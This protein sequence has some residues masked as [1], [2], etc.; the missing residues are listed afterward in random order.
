MTT[1]NGHGFTISPPPKFRGD[2]TISE[3]RTAGGT[4]F[5]VKD[6]LSG[7][8]F[9]LGEA[10]RFIAGQF[11]GT[12]SL[13]TVRDRVEARF[14]AT[15]PTE[16]L[17]AFVRKVEKA[18][19]L[20]TAAGT[21]PRPSSVAQRRLR[22]NLL[23]L[24]FKLLDPDRIL[25]WLVGRVR[26]CFT[27]AFLVFAGAMI[28]FAAGTVTANWSEVGRNLGAVLRWSA[29][30]AYLAVAFLVISAH[31]FAHGL[32]CKHFGGEV[33]EMG[34]LLIYFQPALYCNVSDAW[35]FPEKSK[36]LWVGFAGPFFELFLWALA[37]LTW[38]L[39]ET[40]TWLNY[41]AF[42]VVT[43]SGIKTLFNFNPLIKLDGYYLLSDYLGIPNLRKKSFRHLGNRIKEWLGFSAASAQAAPARERKIF[44]LYGLVATAGSLSLLAYVAVQAGGFLIEQQQMLA[45]L[46]LSGLVSNRLWRRFRKLFGRPSRAAS[47]FDGDDELDEPDT[48]GPS[49][50][51]P[52]R[53]KRSRT[54]MRWLRWTALTGA[55]CA[56]LFLGRME[57]RIAGPFNIL[58]RENA[59]VRAGVEGIIETIHVDEGDVVKVG[60]LVARL[61]DLDLLAELRQ[62][63][64]EIK[65]TR[66][67]LMM[68]EAGPTPEEIAVARTL[69]AKAED[70]R[71]YALGRLA[72]DQ[73][74]FDQRL[75]SRKELEDTQ[76]LA[77]TAGNDLEEARTRLKILLRGT[78]PEE[79]AATKAG[80]DR[81]EAQRLHLEERLRLL[82][83]VSPAD[84]IVATPTRQLKELKRQL[85]N[86]GDLI[87][88]V[89]DFRTVTAEILIPEKEIAD[90]QVGQT[91][92]LKARAYP[93]QLFHGKVTAI[94]T[95]ALGH[96]SPAEAATPLTS[97][98][99]SRASDSNKSV[100]VTTQIENAAL[101]LKPEMTGQ[102]KIHCGEQRIFD[103]VTRRLARVVKVEFWS[104]W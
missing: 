97:S 27:P 87:A 98:S 47:P 79:I 15:V 49:T 95:A 81:L 99:A 94:A 65:Q 92:L 11:D 39:T 78:R 77:A 26:F 102:A 17:T 18:G 36:R 48:P 24:R 23:Y 59:D 91:V 57:L 52:P 1:N 93:D 42:I 45:L 86:R 104:W 37:V 76:E 4:V 61:S 50:P 46:L 6:P 70:R 84:G 63:E 29:I 31:E 66:A 88:K 40:G 58:P 10:E 14:G 22:G 85:V 75:L 55:A 33:R 64:A 5:V 56:V 101:L 60:D 96:S 67:R 44:L 28:L 62:T 54:L 83:V 53:R 8:F 20:E 3:Q 9:R 69:V 51:V 80:V 30:P 35:L 12:T 25:N 89:Y 82:K 43:T 71:K 2:L 21:A 7:E 34:F 19:L 90:I 68:L 103:L 38:R 16:T 32:T 100:L 74:L 13:D 41:F 73:S 72:R